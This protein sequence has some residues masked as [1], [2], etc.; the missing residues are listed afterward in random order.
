MLMMLGGGWKDAEK[1]TLFNLFYK[2][3]FDFTETTVPLL[4]RRLISNN[5]NVVSSN[6]LKIFN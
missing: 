1:F 3:Y 6:W 4:L 2:T 5:I